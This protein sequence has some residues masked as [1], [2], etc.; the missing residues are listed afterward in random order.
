[1]KTG[2][3]LILPMPG[4]SFDPARIAKA[5]QDAGFST[6]RVEVV[7]EGKVEKFENLLA[8]RVPGLLRPFVLEGGAKISELKAKPVGSAVK[9]TGVLH[10]SHGDK[11]PGLSVEEIKESND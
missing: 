3:T 9:I 10:G 5:I 8:L 11:P 4:Q 1:M 6:P 7:A 2:L